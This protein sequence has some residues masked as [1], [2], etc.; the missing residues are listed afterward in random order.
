M[1]TTRTSRTRRRSE[2]SD[3]PRSTRSARSARSSRRESSKG[4]SAKVTGRFITGKA[5]SSFMRVI[6]LEEDDNGNKVC[7]TGIMIPKKD[8][9]TVKALKETIQAVARQKFGNEIDIFKS[10]KMHNPLLDGDEA[11]DDPE[12]PSV[13]NESRG[14]YLLNAKAYK[15]PQVVDKHNERITDIDELEEICV[16]GFWFRFSLTFKAFDNESRGVRVLLNNLMFVEEG[17]RLDGGKSAEEDFEDFAEEGDDDEG[18]D[19]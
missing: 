8:R 17:E 16:S 3:A 11:A 6:K 9:K 15:L 10:K 14:Y 19:D 2:E 1:A 18:W 7:K 4:S 13:G 5:R 12:I